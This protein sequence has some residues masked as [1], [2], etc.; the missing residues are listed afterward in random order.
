MITATEAG[1]AARAYLAL[2]ISTIPLHR[3]TVEGGCSCSHAD[4]TDAGKHPAVESWRAYQARKPTEDEIAHWYKAPRNVGA[5]TGAISGGLVVIDCDDPETYHAICYVYPELRVSLTVRTGKGFHVYCYAEPVGTITFDLNG[6]RHHVKA[7]GGYVVAPPS[8]HAS[9]RVYEF[10]DPEAPPIVLDLPRFRDAL[11]RL[12][13]KKP[14]QDNGAR[15]ESGWAS[16]YI[17]DGATRGERDT[18]TFELAS[19]LA[20]NLPEDVTQ[21]I[22]ELWA[23]HRCDQPWGAYDVEKKVRSVRRYAGTF[24]SD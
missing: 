19:Y 1:E 11:R 18:R 9:G 17:R 2:G 15:R 3:P 20:N 7:E 12:G 13:A 8:L 10:V 16:Q 5:I 4:C 24:P 14:D 6:K 22:L 23:E 21:A